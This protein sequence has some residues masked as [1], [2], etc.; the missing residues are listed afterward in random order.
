[1]PGIGD[2]IE[3]RLKPHPYLPKLNQKPIKKEVR[4]RFLS[5]EAGQQKSVD[6]GV[7]IFSVF[8]GK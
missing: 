2:Y 4:H 6:Y 5:L 7:K 3:G 1:V 8:N